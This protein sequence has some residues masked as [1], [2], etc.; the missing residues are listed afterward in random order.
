MGSRHRHVLR[1]VVTACAVAAAVC[2]TAAGGAAGTDSK[3]A[4]LASAGLFGQVRSDAIFFDRMKRDDPYTIAQ[5]QAQL[6]VSCYVPSQIQQAYGLTVLYRENITGKGTKIVIVDPYGSPTLRSDLA[7][8][9]AGTGLPGAWLKI[10]QPLGKVPAYDSTNNDMVG[11]AGETTLDVEWAHAVAPGAG[12]VLV[13]SP[14]DQNLT[15]LNAVRYAVKHR[16]GDVVSESWGSVEPAIGRRGIEQLQ[17]VYSAAV[18]ERMTMVASAG[19]LGAS[20][21]EPDGSS[22]Y[23]YPVASWPA[24]DP[25]VTAVGG[26]SL[27]LGT[28]GNRLSAD[29]GWNDTYNPAVNNLLYDSTPPSPTATGG[30][31]SSVYPRPSFQQSLEKVEGNHRGIPDLS[32]SASCTGTIEVYQS[33]TGQPAGWN[34]VCGTSESSPMFAGIV[35]LAAQLAG[36]PLGLINPAIYE[37]AAKRAKGIVQVTSGNNTVAF[38]NGTST[39]TVHGYYARHGYSLVAGVGTVNAQYLVPELARLS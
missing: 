12:I 19:D 26:T 24:T 3:A 20:G 35:A 13:E 7:T 32:M 36:H 17:G 30:G 33:F 6:Q 15:L 23:S 2:G 4:P 22:F 5:C 9:D 16:L 34:P 10:I 38:S 11:W 18:K 8:F 37:L 1:A 39:E 14:D 31:K 28:D 29:T 25:D 21:V 27:N